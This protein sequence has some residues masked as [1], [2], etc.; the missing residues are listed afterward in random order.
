MQLHVS[1]AVVLSSETYDRVRSEN[2]D[3]QFFTML[4]LIT[5]F[6]CALVRSLFVVRSDMTFEIELPEHNKV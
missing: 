1:L 2:E 3:S 6:E 5:A 4:T